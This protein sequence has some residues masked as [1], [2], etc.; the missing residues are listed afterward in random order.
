MSITIR[1]T[2]PDDIGEKVEFEAASRA[3]TRSEYARTATIAYMSKYPSKGLVADIVAQR[4]TDP[5]NIGL[6]S[7]QGVTNDDTIDSGRA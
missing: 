1:F 7:K 3:M 2:L 6:E 4:C 5:I